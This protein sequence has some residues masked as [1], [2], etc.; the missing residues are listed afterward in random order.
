MART[1]DPADPSHTPF[2]LGV[3]HTLKLLHRLA[4]LD[5]WMLT[6]IEDNEQIVVRADDHGYG[7]EPGTAFDWGNSFCIRM[8]AERGP[9]IAPEVTQVPAY[10]DALAAQ[11]DP[12]A[13][14]S[15]IGFPV[16]DREYGMYGV[17]CAM[18][19]E[20]VSQAIESRAGE[21]ESAV[22]VIE[23][24]LRQ[25]RHIDELERERE[26]LILEAYNDSLTGTR[27]RRGWQIALDAEE[28][29]CE[30][31]SL[32]AGIIALDLDHLKAVNDHEGHDAGDRMIQAAGQA[33]RSASREN[34]VVARLGGDEFGV[35]LPETPADYLPEIADRLRA[36]L[37]AAGV[38]ASIGY[39]CRT[40]SGSLAAAQSN[41]DAAMYADKRQ[42]RGPSA[43]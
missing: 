30:D 26:A 14:G 10:Q 16:H 18:H 9:R 23:A 17:L 39:A 8:L 19:P 6:R 42:R 28:Q 27:N 13:I 15:Y 31:H 40:V 34:D 33:L 35:L 41:A 4:P 22:Q 21:I 3:D 25:R 11:T 24:L 2:N 12:P 32:P 36:A 37:L 43:H 38:E 29:R 1:F 20:P 7:I 5:V